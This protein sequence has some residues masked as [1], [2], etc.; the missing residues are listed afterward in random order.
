MVSYLEENKLKLSI[1]YLYWHEN[2]G[3]IDCA[4]DKIHLAQTKLNKTVK[5]AK[6]LAEHIFCHK[7]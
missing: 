1:I 5:N 7:K 2:K 6:G 4:L 3:D